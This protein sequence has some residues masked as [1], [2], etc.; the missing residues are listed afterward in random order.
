MADIASDFQNTSPVALDLHVPELAM[1]VLWRVADITQTDTICIAGGFVR[2]LYMQQVLGLTPEMKDVDI[3]A[4]ISVEQF[5]AIKDQLH[6]DFG[7]PIRFHIGQFEEEKTQRGLI[8]FGLPKDLMRQ[9]AG[10]ESIQINFGKS[11]SWADPIS[12]VR[13]ANVGINQAAITRESK[14]IASRLFVSDMGNRTMT[15]NSERTWTHNDW[16][17]TVRKLERMTEE[18]DEFEDWRPIPVKKPQTQIG[19]SFWSQK[20]VNFSKLQQ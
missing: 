4:D 5:F 10:V 8:E 12:Y 1:A 9:C 11:H 14:A 17:R 19:G 2:G 7:K 20:S 15:M 13:L 3:F 16:S 6:K 18:R